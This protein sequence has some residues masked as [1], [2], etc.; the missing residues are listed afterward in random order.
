VRPLAALRTSLTKRWSRDREGTITALLAVAAAIA[1]VAWPLSLVTYP[2]L[3]DLPMHAAQTGALRHFWDPSFRFQDQF[4][5][6]PVGT[7]YLSVYAVG[8]FA[9][10]FF[11][12]SVAVRIATAVALLTLPAGVAVLAWGM[13]KSPLLGLAAAPIAWCH[14]VHW[15][16]LNFVTAIGIDAM[17][18]GLALRLV[19]APSRRLQIALAAALVGVFFSHIFRFPFAICGA[20]GAALLAACAK[21]EASGWGPRIKD[22]SRRALVVVAPMVPSLALFAWFW[23]HRSTTTSPSSFDLDLDLGRASEVVPYLVAGFR[24]PAELAS[25]RITLGVLVGVVAATIV[26]RVSVA[27]AA[28][29]A[30]AS[31][32]RFRRFAIA[33]VVG[34]LLAFGFGYFALP[35]EVPN[36]W[37]IYPREATAGLVF[38]MALLP[39]IPRIRGARA[40]VVAA[41]A[42]GGLYFA[43]VPARHFEAFEQKTADFR[44]IVTKIPRAPRLLY[45]VFDHGGSARLVTPWVH[46]PAW[47]QAEKGGWLSFHFALFMTSPFRYRTDPDGIVPPRMPQR[48][49]WE[50]QNFDVLRDASGFDWFL[51]R[52]GESPD[53]YFVGDEEIV[54]VAKD[55]TWWLYRREKRD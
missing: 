44:R 38:A 31:D 37:F 26:A 11:S 10:L 12:A 27:P 20:A 28:P 51:V 7:P 32:R 39:D 46:L 47:V 15:G 3:T 33:A 42:F 24:D 19:D 53:W 43:R 34:N 45:L 55:G 2:P 17:V 14:L 25:A 40:V 29:A 8:A 4:D 35:M 36:W 49:E 50:P 16:F 6:H 22:V 9:M 23:T 48:W 41:L 1:V 21:T 5:L 52:S 18:V 54:P 13:R 30:D